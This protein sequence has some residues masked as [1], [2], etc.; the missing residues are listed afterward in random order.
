MGI[1][2]RIVPVRRLTRELVAS[3]ELQ[4]WSNQELVNQREDQFPQYGSADTKLE[5]KLLWYAN[6]YP[7]YVIRANAKRKNRDGHELLSKTK[8]ESLFQ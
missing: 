2:T 1:Y 5:E 3:I 4:S 6:I 8:E 7:E